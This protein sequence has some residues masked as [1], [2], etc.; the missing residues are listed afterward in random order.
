[1]LDLGW[2]R[3]GEGGRGVWRELTLVRLQLASA[4]PG[5]DAVVGGVLVARCAAG[6]V[7]GLHARV[8]AHA[9]LRGRGRGGEEC[10]EDGGDLHVVG[11]N[12]V[13][14]VDGRREGGR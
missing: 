1:M 8:L 10:E 12:L 13:C 4:A 6:V 9:D 11:V 5:R 3:S 14:S 2:G 7:A